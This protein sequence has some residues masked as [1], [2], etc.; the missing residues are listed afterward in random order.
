LHVEQGFGDTLQFVRYVQ[1]VKERGGRV[2]LE[3]QQG[4]VRLLKNSPEIDH[5]VALGD[6]LPAFDV[7]LPLLSLPLIFQ[8]TLETLPSHVPSVRADAAA[9]EHW[10]ARFASVPGI[11]IGI[12]WQGDPTNRRDCFRSMP[13]ALL[14]PLARVPGVRLFSLQKSL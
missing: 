9:I 14:A 3:C 6:P 2:V 4:L 13:L 8:T 5:V 11:K 12:A 10:R 1:L 7:H